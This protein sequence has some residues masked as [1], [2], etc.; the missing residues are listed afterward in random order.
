MTDADWAEVL[1]VNL[2]SA[3]RL[4]RFAAVRMRAQKGGAVVLVG[5]IN[6][7]RGKAGQ[8]N[9]AASKAGVIALARCAARE[10]GRHGARVNVVNPG[11]IDTAMTAQLPADVRAR[12][13]DESALGRAGQ[14]RDVAAAILFLCSAASAHVTGQVLRVDGGQHIG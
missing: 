1:R 7:E 6:G 12:A 13:V 10:L 3:F 2:D 8:A 5:S 11:L 9:Y 4:L 14:P